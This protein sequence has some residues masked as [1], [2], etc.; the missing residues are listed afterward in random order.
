MNVKRILVRQCKGQVGTRRGVVWSAI[1]FADK[2]WSWQGETVQ[3]SG[4]SEEAREAPSLR[5][6]GT[7]TST[8]LLATS[9]GRHRTPLNSRAS[10]L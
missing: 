5:D 2:V 9:L 1:D 7:R 8:L 6:L 10:R 3:K 4:E